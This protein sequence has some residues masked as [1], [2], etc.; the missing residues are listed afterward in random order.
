M[1]V[2]GE[3]TRVRMNLWRKIWFDTWGHTGDSLTARVKMQ[4]S[5]STSACRPRPRV[6]A[7]F[8]HLQCANRPFLVS[9]YN[10]LSHSL[11]TFTHGLKNSLSE[12]DFAPVQHTILFFRFQLERTHSF[13]CNGACKKK[14]CSWKKNV[15]KKIWKKI[16]DKK[17]EKE[18]FG[19]KM[20]TTKFWKKKISKQ[21]IYW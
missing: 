21:N 14:Q 16:L 11:K 10:I 3:P 1:S 5:P 12:I 6:H 7:A 19:K 17:F 4:H 20:L 2:N 15:E 18:K 8:L 9:K 13:A